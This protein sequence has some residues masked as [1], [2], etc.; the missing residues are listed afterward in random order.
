MHVSKCL[1]LVWAFCVVQIVLS[2]TSIRKSFTD[3]FVFTATDEVD[4]VRRLL[5]SS[6][7][8]QADPNDCRCPTSPLSR[9]LRGSECT[10]GHM[11]ATAHR[12]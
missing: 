6:T 12:V 10:G 9:G 5:V 8:T 1:S 3:L 2:A 4:E 7:T 11:L